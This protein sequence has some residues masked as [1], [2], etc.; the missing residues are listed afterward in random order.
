MKIKEIANEKDMTT[1]MKPPWL[2]EIEEFPLKTLQDYNDK[3]LR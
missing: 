2:L 3:T 1:G